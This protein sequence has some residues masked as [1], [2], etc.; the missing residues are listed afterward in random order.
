M[1]SLDASYRPAEP[2]PT[3]LFLDTSGLF[4]YFHPDVDEHEAAQAFLRR[5]GAGEIPYRPLY[6]S[7]YVVDELVTLLQSKGRRAWAVDAFEMVTGS[8]NFTVFGETNERFEAAGDRFRRY[9][10]HEMSFTDCFCSVVMDEENVDY[11]FAYDGD[12]ATLGHTV[13]PRTCS[14]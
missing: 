1:S 4:A 6:T 9:D 13:V 2:G 7:T 10:D 5:V 12:Y 3:A 14:E 8:D 11:V